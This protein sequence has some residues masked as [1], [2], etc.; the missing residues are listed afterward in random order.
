MCVFTSS[1]CCQF[2][3]TRS[4][5]P[6]NEGRQQE[7]MVHNRQSVASPAQ[8]LPL[9]AGAGLSH[10]LL[11]VWYPDP[12][13]TPQVPQLLHDAHSPSTERGTDCKSCKMSLT[14]SPLTLSSF[15]HN[16]ERFLSSSTLMITP[17]PSLLL[18]Y[19]LLVLHV[20]RTSIIQ[21]DGNIIGIR[22]HLFSN[23]TQT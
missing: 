2:L 1:C 11:R 10:V 19:S 7:E 5:L 23:C 8:S 15:K 16:Y 20:P 9:C 21:F 6:Y 22:G 3:L 17:Y 13:V 14:S 18:S 12:H 4:M